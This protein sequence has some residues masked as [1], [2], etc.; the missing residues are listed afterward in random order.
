MSLHRLALG[1][2]LLAATIP[3]ARADQQEYEANGLPPGSLASSLPGN[4]DLGGHRQWLADRGINYNLWYRNDTLANLSGGTR[5][6]TV[7]QGLLETSVSVDFGR[8]AGLDGLSFFSNQF[9]IHNTGRMRRDYVGGINTIAAIEGVPT[10]R[11]SE[12]WLE[13][14]LMDGRVRLRAGQLAADVDFFFS[15]TSAMFLQSDF[16]TISALALPSGGPAFPLAT[17]G[18]FLAFDATPDITLQMAIYNGDPAGP[19]A[20]DEQV[21]NHH[22]TNFRMRD[23]ALIFAEAQFRANQAAE[24]AGLARTLKLGGWAHLGGFDDRRLADDRGPLADPNG[25]GTP[26]RRRGNQGV[27]GV[28][29]QQIYRP[30]GGDASSGI[31]AFGRASVSPGDS[32]LVGLYLDGGLVFAGFVPGR[33]EDR[34]GVSLMYARFSDA[35]RGFD[36]DAA[37]FAG[38][39]A[40]RDYEMN[41]EVSYVAEILPGLSVQPMLARVWHPNGMPGRDAVVAGLRTHFR[42]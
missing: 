37:G 40:V 9:L 41:L 23:P 38:G 21:R 33:P 35:V 15:E 19:G 8:L 7:N 11:L 10:V 6:G 34:F 32:S 30:E 1:L 28:F 42:F 14:K 20:G 5:R 4:G 24:D 31:T 25:S 3:G 12:F 22:G 16:A 39:G 29:D 2:S 13:Q 26:L 27:Y 17:P 36:R 18:A